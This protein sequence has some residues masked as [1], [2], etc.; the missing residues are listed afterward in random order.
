MRQ[1]GQDSIA[2]EMAARHQFERA[3]AL[4]Q[5]GQAL[6]AELLCIELLTRFPGHPDA[7]MQ[8]A[9]LALRRGDA[10]RAEAFLDQAV[11][12]GGWTA[13]LGLNLAVVQMNL[14]Q[15]ALAAASLEATVANAPESAVAWLML[16]QVREEE[17]KSAAA[18]RAQFNAV[19]RAQRS[20]HWVDESSTP[21]QLLPSVL[22][23]I[24]RVRR[25]RR[26]LLRRD[27]RRGAAGPRP[28]LH[29]ACRPCLVRIPARLGLHAERS[30]PAAEVLLLSGLAEHRVPRPVSSTL[31]ASAPSRVSR[32]FARKPFE[33]SKKTGDCRISSPTAFVSKT[34]FQ[35]WAPHHRGRHSSSIG[36]ASATMPITRGARGPAQCSSRSTFAASRIRH[37]KS[38][39]RS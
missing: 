28:S 6:Q 38:C 7:S 8:V 23:A 17:G 21:A 37:R 14:G 25:G 15:T 12:I 31:G 13:S 3:K 27:C 1:A 19:T 36:M 9:E 34:S 20:G 16:G 32:R 5:S 26:E 10:G 39:S 30:A 24:D 29:D 2:D 22:H 4:A 11:R 35:V 18:L 33:S